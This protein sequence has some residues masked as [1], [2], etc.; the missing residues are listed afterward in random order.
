M[1]R[2]ITESVLFC[3]VRRVL[4]ASCQRHVSVV[5]GRRCLAPGKER[6]PAAWLDVEEPSTL[7]S[8]QQTR[9]DLSQGGW[10]VR[11]FAFAKGV[12][13]KLRAGS[14][15]R[16]AAT[17]A[18]V[19]SGEGGRSRFLKAWVMHICICCTATYTSVVHSRIRSSCP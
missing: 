14:M 17:T 8:V 6:A 3:V 18:S 2:S 19:G 9:V 16:L 1:Y 5:Q 12:G 15:D 13:V 7:T 11:F 10:V 4:I